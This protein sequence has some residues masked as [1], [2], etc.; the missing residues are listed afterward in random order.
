MSEKTNLKIS[1]IGSGAWGS[2]IANLIAKN[3]F[4][5]RVITNDEKS[6]KE[7]NEKHTNE[8]FLPE[9]KIST[10]VQAFAGVSQEALGDTDLIFIVTPSQTVENILKQLSELNLKEN[11]GF[12]IC[13]KGLDQTKLQFF[14][15]IFKDIFPNKECA[16]LS[17]PNFAL[18]VAQE[19]PTITTIASKDE[20]LANEVISVLQNEYFQA[21]YSDDPITTEIS[22]VLKNVMAIGC[23]ISDGL[24]LG[25]NAKAAIV[26]KGIQEILL[27]CKRLGGKE[28]LHN[29]AG[30]G[31]IFLT[32]STTKSRNNSLGYQIA[33]GNSYAEIISDA[34]K[35]FEG[36]TSVKSLVK[37]AKKM[38]IELKLCETVEEILDNDFSTKQIKE[39][40]I[41]S[42]LVR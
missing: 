11:I 25:Q 30:F 5:V 38:Q 29:S 31:D 36:A 7:I 16:V 9:I 18:E 24:D 21:E 42:I 34:S 19:V 6:V 35:T 15:Q 28:N 33:Q 3:S 8:V 17:G 40:L 26:N 41:K 2:A 23:G 37:L 4:E 20:K 32:C 39:K 14:S 27:L 1:V 10:L 22:A 13:S 12:V